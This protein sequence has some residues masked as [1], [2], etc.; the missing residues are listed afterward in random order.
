MKFLSDDT[1]ESV[2]RGRILGDPDAPPPRGRFTLYDRPQPADPDH[3]TFKDLPREYGTV[4]VHGRE[5]DRSARIVVILLK[6]DDY[7]ANLDRI[8]VISGQTI[9]TDAETEVFGRV[10][11]M[12]HLFRANFRVPIKVTLD[13]YNE[14]LQAWIANQ[15]EHVWP[16]IRLSLFNGQTALQV[17]QQSQYK[18]AVLAAIM[19]LELW[20]DRHRF[21]FD[22]NRL[23]QTL[24][25]P[26][27]ES[28]DPRDVNI[29][30]L[31][32]TRLILVD[33][34][35]LSDD[36]LTFLF[37]VTSVRRNGSF[38]YKIGSEVL[39]RPAMADRIDLIE[40]HERLTELA[41]TSDDQLEHLRLARDIAVSRGESPAHWLV[42]EL[43]VRLSRME[44]DPAKRLI[45][46][47]QS[48][49]LREPGIG[50]SFAAVV[51][52]YG[53]V[54]QGDLSATAAELTSET[55]TEPETAAAPSG[56]VWTPESNE[57]APA[58]GDRDKESKLWIPGMD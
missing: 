2:P 47:I 58:E 48:R 10:H 35:K 34:D 53:L 15:L 33:L 50:Q 22:F 29:R 17:A 55:V 8:S 21:D 24:N 38:L 44:I 27:R 37:E 18:K 7:A 51:E 32:P 26:I 13:R 3:A 56:R 46:E 45:S 30:A 42:R 36:D 12:Q 20:S 43:D 41:L 4:T 49:Y 11:R 25:L 1:V 14:L 5:T 31:S 6:D 39:K 57:P 40:V 9:S 16:T 19:N 23:R 52:K 28:L 54:S